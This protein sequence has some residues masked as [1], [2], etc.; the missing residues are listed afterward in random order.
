[1]IFSFDV[2]RA[3]KGDCLL[4]HFGTRDDAGLVMIDG[5]PSSVYRPQL[6]P[7]LKEIRAAR[8]L[9]ENDLLIVDLMMVSHV[10]DDHIKGLLDLTREEL[11][12]KRDHRPRLLNVQSFWHNSF[13]SIIGQTPDELAAS[14][15]GEFEAATGGG[16]LSDETRAQIEVLSKEEPE[17]VESGL[18]VLASIAQG[19]QLRVNAEG[20][21]YPLTPEF[22]GG[23]VIA[24]EGDEPVQFV[25]NLT[26][27]VVGPMKP[28]L[29]ALHKKHQEWLEDLRKKGKSPPEALAA[30]LDTSVPNLSSIVVLAETGGKR[31]LLTGDARGDKIIEGLQLVGLMGS[32]DDSKIKVDVLKVPHHGSARNLE[33]D[34][35]ERILADHY[36]FSGNGE[37]GNPERE[38]LEMLYDARG[39]T[40]F[41]V[42]LTYPVAEIDELREKDWEKEQAKEKKRNAAEVREDWSPQDHGLVAFLAAR[43]AGGRQ[44]VEIVG[45]GAHVIDLLEPL[46]F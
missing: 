30:Y 40:P 45:D 15:K 39:D 18:K 44:K 23:L 21:E 42:H 6:K 31:I 24:G 29:A 38:A 19:F 8:Q 16:S 9:G 20:L 11:E 27:T 2:R 37:H 33:T 35:F 46:G 36:V 7:R 26:L 1:M 17:V 32:E 41:T 43:S 25:P 5:G 12:A 22:D 28:E 4:L 14:V 34:F 13:D 10:D 3:R